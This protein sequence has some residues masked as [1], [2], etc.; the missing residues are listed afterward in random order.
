MTD[1]RNRL[2]KGCT[3]SKIWV[4]RLITGKTPSEAKRTVLNSFLRLGLAS[5]LLFIVFCWVRW[6]HI[7]TGFL[8]AYLSALLWLNLGPIL[9]WYYDERLLPNFFHKILDI[10]PHRRKVRALAEKYDRLFSKK[11]WII[12]IPWN[13]LLIYAFL[14]SQD[15]L[16]QGGL[17]GYADVFYWILF[18]GAVWTLSLTGIGFWGI[19]VMLLAVSEISRQSLRIDPLHPDK[20]G[21][22]SCVGYY[23]IGT[24][25]LFSSGSLF[26][27][28]VFQLTTETN[29]AS[30]YIYLATSVF[31]FFILLSFLY[32]TVRIH[33]KAKAARDSILDRLRKRHARLNSELDISNTDALEALTSH[34]EII[35]LR[36]EY[37]DYRNVK[38]YPF[39]FETFLKLAS[40]VILP[41]VFLLV[42]RYWSSLI[43]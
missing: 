39:E 8:V 11:Y 18:A 14:G 33:G 7:S 34:L 37:Q 13:I 30:I 1:T 2:V 43:R 42:Q 4:T 15:V 31:S 38:L 24:T 12:V 5:D 10:V 17:L 23:A 20:L 35:R 16:V 28:L 22:L 19:L 41:V 9:I 40:S 6:Q 27:P 3:H 32:P 21:G 25:V 26:L 36:S 29:V